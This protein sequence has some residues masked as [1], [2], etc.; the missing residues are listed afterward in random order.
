MSF[1]AVFSSLFTAII[2][3]VI[4][5]G[6]YF[7]FATRR[8]ASE[9]ERLVPASGKFIT[10]DGNR[11]HYVDEGEGPPILFLHGLGAQLH[12]FR[13]PL[14]ESFGAGYRLIAL[15]RP[16]SGYSVRARGSTGGLSEQA[17]FIKRFC[18]ETGIE[19]PLVV[20]H[21]LGGAIALALAV[22]HPEA[23]SG[24][25][26]LSPLSHMFEEVP[27]EFK[28]LYIKNGAKRWLVS[29]TV[30]VPAS[31]KNA[32]KTLNFVFGPQPIPKD[33]AIKGGGYA[34]LR[35]SHIFGTASDVVA[36]ENDLGRIEARYGEID[37]PVGIMFGGSDRVLD[38][39]VHGKMLAETIPNAEFELLEGVGHMPQYAEKTRVIAFIRRFADRVFGKISEKLPENS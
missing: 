30:A 26:L 11:V 25:V 38:H 16:G 32:E 28:P 37:M 18:E 8:I 6:G 19:K 39:R 10:V 7:L 4:L 13:Y 35:P 14:F 21:S 15:D 3:V 23:I 31:L 33:Y 27:P 2:L 1:A 36:V 29:H 20:G 17:R 5:I 12:N 22:E 24:V 34:G 9:A